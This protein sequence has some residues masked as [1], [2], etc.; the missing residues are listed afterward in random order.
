VPYDFDLAGLVNAAYAKPDPSLRLR[1]VTR[2]RY[3]GYCVSQEALRGAI[4]IVKSKRKDILAV[5]TGIP[6]YTVKEMEDN[7]EYLDGFF[8]LAQ[9]EEKLLKSFERS[10]LK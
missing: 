9:D 2:R 1:S 7:I 10:C 3:R 5:L 4:Q 8:E 6:G